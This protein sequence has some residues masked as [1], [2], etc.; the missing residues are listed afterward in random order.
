[1]LQLPL[2]FEIAG[3]MFIVILCVPVCDIKNFEIYLSL[4][5]KPFIC[6]KKCFSDGIGNIHHEVTATGLEPEPL[7]S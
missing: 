5:I 7:S 3:D 6:Y 2:L 4:L 1:M